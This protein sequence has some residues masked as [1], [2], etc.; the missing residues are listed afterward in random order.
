M[1][2]AFG[3]LT[4][5]LRDGEV[6]VG[7]GAD[8]DW[9]VPTADLMPR[10]FTLTVHGLNASLKPA[11]KETVVVVNGT[12]LASAS[13]LLNE[14]DVILAGSGR[15]VF[16]DDAPRIAPAEPEAEEPAYLADD[17]EKR[18]YPLVNR[19]TTLGRDA[20][21]AIV[22]KDPSASRFHAEVR[23]EAGGFVLHSMGSGGTLLNGAKLAAPRLLEENDTVEIAFQTLRFTRLAAPASFTTGSL[24][25]VSHPGQRNPTLATGKIS[26]VPASRGVTVAKVVFG[27]ILIALVVLAFMVAR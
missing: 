14:G 15:F 10:H 9:R 23:R 7:S 4:R 25:R 24:G 3:T 1:W 26:L 11:S 13:H 18:V 22:V 6:V 27:A 8:A 12:Q 2:L 21:N 19:S 5:E 20:S 16:S 17:K